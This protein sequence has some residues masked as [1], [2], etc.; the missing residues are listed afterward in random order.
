LAQNLENHKFGFWPKISILTEIFQ[1][2][3]QLQYFFPICPNE[4]NSISV[5]TNGTL[6]IS[7][8][9]KVQFWDISAKTEITESKFPMIQEFEL[10]DH[11]YSLSANCQQ[12]VVGTRNG[13]IY[14]LSLDGSNE[15][16]PSTSLM[17]DVSEHGNYIATGHANGSVKLW[18][19]NYTRSWHLVV[20]FQAKQSVH[21][22]SMSPGI[23]L[24]WVVKMAYP[25][26]A[27]KF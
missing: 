24:A 11:C 2:C 10:D 25:G 6:V 15:L 14:Y 9:N 26:Y 13:S 27:R 3:F 19:P 8:E 22:V 5:Q 21:C 23:L 16:A 4:I 1:L 18:Q 12:A 17:T 7:T 20:Q